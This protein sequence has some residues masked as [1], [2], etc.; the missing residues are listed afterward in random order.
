M[1]GARRHQ[2]HPLVF[3]TRTHGPRMMGAR[4]AIRWALYTALLLTTLALAPFRGR[5][6]IYFQF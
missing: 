1:E 4:I 2:P 5:E 3:D 6:F